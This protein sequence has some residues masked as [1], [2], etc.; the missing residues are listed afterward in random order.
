MLYIFWFLHQTTTRTY[1]SFV[2]SKLYIFWFLHQTT[3]QLCSVNCRSWLYI[4]WFL[5]QTTTQVIFIMRIVQLYI[6][7]FLHQTTTPSWFY[8]YYLRCISFDSYIKPQHAYTAYRLNSVV[9][10][11]IPTS[12]HNSVAA[13]AALNLLYIFWFLHQTT[14]LMLCCLESLVL[15]IFWFLHQT[16][17]WT[18]SG[19]PTS[20]LYIF[21]FL[22]QTTTRSMNISAATRCISFD[23]Y[24]KPQPKEKIYRAKTVVYLLIPTSNHNLQIRTSWFSAHNKNSI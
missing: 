2:S 4:F 18:T 24:I 1:S 22:H 6:F 11:L 3:T 17:T 15:Y 7:W 5:H 10:L 12:N 8:H 13:L 23:S 14:T 21:W 16:T 9:Y 20:W 19:I